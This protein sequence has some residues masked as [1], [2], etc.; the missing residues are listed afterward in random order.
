MIARFCSMQ[1]GQPAVGRS[2]WLLHPWSAAKTVITIILVK[3]CKTAARIK[4]LGL[5]GVNVIYLKSLVQNLLESKAP[6]LQPWPSTPLPGLLFLRPVLATHVTFDRLTLGSQRPREDCNAPNV[7]GATAW[8]RLYS[9]THDC[10]TCCHFSWSS[11]RLENKKSP[12]HPRTCL[13]G[14]LSMKTRS[15][16][17]SG[18][19]KQGYCLNGTQSA[20]SWFY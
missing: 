18:P 20:V 8:L 17:P 1:A 2:L 19:L 14:F 10:R 3:K 5:S 9:D 12:W 11:F 13:G 16:L 15:P 4:S 6:P 7:G